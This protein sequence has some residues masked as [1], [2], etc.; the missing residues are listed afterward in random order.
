MRR[1]ILFIFFIHILFNG[2]SPFDG[3]ELQTFHDLEYRVADRGMLDV[4]V[5]GRACASLLQ[6]AI[7]G[8]KHTAE[9]HLRSVVG[10]QKHRKKFQEVDRYYDGDK[11]CVEM[12]AAALPPL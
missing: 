11:I 2:C 1:I 4:I 12:S 3:S 8:A 7:S 5:I 9:F 10:N 6:N